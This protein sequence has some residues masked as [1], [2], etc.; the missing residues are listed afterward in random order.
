MTESRRVDVDT[1][2]SRL[3]A[4]YAQHI[5]DTPPDSDFDDIA[6]LAGQ[7][8]QTPI[9]LLSLVDADRQWFKARVGLDVCETPRSSSFCAYAMHSTGVMQ[10]PDTLDDHRFADNPLV[11]GEPHIRFYAGAPLVSASGQP[12]GSVCVIDRVP[13]LLT[14]EQCHG[15]TA[16]AR[17]AMAQLEI[18][19]YAR[20]MDATNRRLREADRLKDDFVSRVTHELR[21]PLTSIRGYVE[22]LAEA[23]PSSGPGTGYVEKIQ[24]NSDR[25]MRLVDDM[26]LVAQLGAGDMVLHRDSVDL[27]V[28]ARDS[29][30]QNGPFAAGKGLTM[31]IDATAPVVVHADRRLIA[32]VFDRLVGNAI[33]FTDRGHIGVAVSSDSRRVTVRVTDTGVGVDSD[34]NDRLF[35]PFRRSATAERREVQGAGLGLSIVKAIV[36]SHGGT[37]AIHGVPGGGTTVT[38]SLPVAG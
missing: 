11:V 6:V 14:P 2:H 8:C 7:L 19:E 5:L 18:R 24:R 32:Q 27:A 36:D 38:I 34:H 33:K 17:Q 20:E 4:L 9:A 3:S 21:T 30:H 28:L 10:V 13:R 1:E 12:L 15:L 23:Q 25:L 22:M 31:A 35:A 37:A 26:L 16:L 29:V